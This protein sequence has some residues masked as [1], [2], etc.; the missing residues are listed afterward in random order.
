MDHEK[1][2][3]F[4]YEEFVDGYVRLILHTQISERIK[5]VGEWE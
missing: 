2:S 3:R 5:M 1:V 4:Q